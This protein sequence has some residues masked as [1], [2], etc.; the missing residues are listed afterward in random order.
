[1]YINESEFQ[2]YFKN[3]LER[4][5]N[6]DQKSDVKMY[7]FFLKYYQTKKLFNDCFH[8]SLFFFYEIFRQT[9]RS[10][11]QIELEE[12]GKDFYSLHIGEMITWSQPILPKIEHMLGMNISKKFDLFDGA[13]GEKIV[14]ID[15]YDYYY[16]RLSHSNFD[17]FIESY[18]NP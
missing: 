5:K 13:Y 3:E 12:D 2:E 18:Q 9:V 7:S 15:V 10:L 11:F 1:M 4:F 14:Y 6:L 17:H 8:P 16:L